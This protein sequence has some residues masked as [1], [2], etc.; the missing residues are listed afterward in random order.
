VSL[1]PYKFLVISV[2][3][4]VNEDGAVVNEVSTE[5]PDVCFGI[6][7]LVSYAESF[8]Q[9]LAQREAQMNGGSDGTQEDGGSSRLQGR[10]EPDRE[11]VGGVDEGSRGH[12]RR[13]HAQGQPRR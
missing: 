8:E 7:G 6:S 1:R 3:Q 9:I 10:A 5:Q 12:P 4:Q 11:E 2:A 13:E